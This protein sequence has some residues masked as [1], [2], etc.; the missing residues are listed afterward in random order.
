MS[1]EFIEWNTF[2]KAI[3]T[4]IDTRTEYKKKKIKKRVGKLGW[5]MSDRNRNIP[6]T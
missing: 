1:G 3:K 5:F 2:E 4:E 6:T